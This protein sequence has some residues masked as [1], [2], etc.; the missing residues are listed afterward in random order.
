MFGP[1]LAVATRGGA[2]TPV[3]LLQ[4]GLLSLASR[5]V[6]PVRL[7]HPRVAQSHCFHRPGSN[8]ADLCKA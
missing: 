3:L 8:M 7:A 1:V 5:R 2:E 4:I 6:V